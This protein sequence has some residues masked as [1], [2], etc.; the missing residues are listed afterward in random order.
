[1]SDKQV[2]EKIDKEELKRLEEQAYFELCQIIAEALQLQDIELLD[3]RIATWKKK[4]KK[5]LDSPYSSNFK[6]R[7][8]FLLN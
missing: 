8:E 4:Y 2:K 6:K 1:M 3:I 7:I 5:L